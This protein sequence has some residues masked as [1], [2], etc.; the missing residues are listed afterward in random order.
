MSERETSPWTV[1]FGVGAAVALGTMLWPKSKAMAAI[2]V[3]KPMAIAIA[4]DFMLEI[5]RAAEAWPLEFGSVEPGK[6]ASRYVQ[7]R[8]V[9]GSVIP[10]EATLM[11]EQDGRD[12]FSVSGGAY[13]LSDR[14]VVQ[15]IVSGSFFS[16]SLAEDDDREALSAAIRLALMHELTH[17][18]DVFDVT[19]S[20]NQRRFKAKYRD[21]PF[22]YHNEPIEVRAYVQEVLHEIETHLDRP[23]ARPYR[24]Y[25][26]AMTPDKAA[27][28]TIAWN[29]MSKHLTE[30]NRRYI[31]KNV[32]QLL[33]RLREEA[34]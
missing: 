25:L 1:A 27:D 10:V 34:S 21:N 12:G 6:I 13:R 9:D 5:V 19:T 30:A 18:A 23:S 14:T 20:A 15:V 17:A 31:L 33:T 11:V 2:R 8:A 32:A 29:Q 26:L 22:V 3:D 7:V 16:K 28:W 24:P 4:D